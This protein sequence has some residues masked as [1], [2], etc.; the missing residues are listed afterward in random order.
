MVEDNGP[1]KP[2]IEAAYKYNE[3]TSSE[4]GRSGHPIWKYKGREEDPDDLST[5]AL[6]KLES[7]Y[8]S[9]G[10]FTRD[11]VR[12][13]GELAELAR[14]RD[15]VPYDP[16]FGEAKVLHRKEFENRIKDDLS[17]VEAARG[18]RMTDRLIPRG[19]VLV[20]LDLDNFKEKIN[21][22][23][24][25]IA[26]DYALSSLVGAMREVFR[27]EDLIGR[28]GNGD[29]FGVWMAGTDS[30]VLAAALAETRGKNG[31]RSYGI[32]DQIRNR[33]NEILESKMGELPERIGK[34][35]GR[36]ANGR[37]FDFTEGIAQQYIDQS[38][39]TSETFR[40]MYD[41]ADLMLKN[42]K[43]LKKVGR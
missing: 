3:I 39:D 24:G 22:R 26:G 7:S 42:N 12:D 9:G 25:H 41:I 11:S 5:R 29:E 21:D 13:A 43:G 30:E 27:V 36:D 10:E 4:S 23:L 32:L 28:L 17:Q 38:M 16:Q 14:Y 6:D 8:R 40:D 1:D 19:R 2:S 20:I 31:E 15:E 33:M 34:S 35:W 18:M 37:F